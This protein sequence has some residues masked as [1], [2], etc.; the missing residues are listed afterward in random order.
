MAKDSYLDLR[1]L[2][3]RKA[4]RHAFITLLEEKEFN[5]ISVNSIAQKAEINRVTFTCT[6][7]T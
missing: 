7:K 6:I 4:I 5:K 1:V 2:R 3:T